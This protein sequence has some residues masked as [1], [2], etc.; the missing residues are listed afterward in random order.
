M[1]LC[2]SVHSFI[3]SFVGSF[4]HGHKLQYNNSVSNYYQILCNVGFNLAAAHTMHLQRAIE[5]GPQN[6]QRMVPVINLFYCIYVS[7]GCWPRMG[8][9]KR[10]GG[11][12]G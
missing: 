4:F 7:C 6:M 10:E 9:E 5:N 11:G 3:H 1:A 2:K 12:G 8:S